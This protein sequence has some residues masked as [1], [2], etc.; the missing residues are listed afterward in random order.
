M[1]V[2]Y[3]FLQKAITNKNYISFTYENKLYK[4]IKALNLDD[5]S[6]LHSDKNLFDFKK[7][8]K[9]QISKNKFQQ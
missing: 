3:R 7:I 2:E 4:N 9:L 1:N 5:K 8:T 6:I